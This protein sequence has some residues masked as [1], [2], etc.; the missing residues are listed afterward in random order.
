MNEDEWL[1]WK[2]VFTNKTADEI[3]NKDLL[4]KTIALS[5]N[6][7]IITIWDDKTVDENLNIIK[8]KIDEICKH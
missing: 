8:E 3:K 1:N 2:Q 4:K 7:C 6:H 5:K